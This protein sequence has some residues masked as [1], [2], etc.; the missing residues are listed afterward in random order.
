MT[1][2]SRIV[3]VRMASALLLSLF[4]ALVPGCGLL[5]APEKVVTAV[6]PKSKQPDPLDLQLQLQRYADDY[7]ARSEQGLDAYAREVGTESAQITAL[8]FKLIGGASI[9]AIVSGPNPSANLL[10]LVSV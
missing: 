9:I 5:R 2:R 7:L 8:R 1:S 10:D 3:G 6:V 4:G